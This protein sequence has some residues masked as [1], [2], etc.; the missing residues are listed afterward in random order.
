MAGSS[1]LA[2]AFY[3]LYFALGIPAL[4]WA[5]PRLPLSFMYWVARWA[6]IVP[7]NLVRPKYLRAI[8]GNLSRVLARPAGHPEVRRVAWQMTFEHAYHWIDFFRWSQATTEALVAQISVIEGAEHFEAAR[9]SGHGTLLLSAHMGNP[10]IGAAT[11]G[12]DLEPVHILYWRDRFAKAED[13]RTQMRLKGNVHGIPVDASLFSVVPALRVLEDG[14]IVAAH[15][16]RDFNDQ[17]WPAEFFGAPASFPPGP[18]LL[19]ARANALVIPTFFL[20][21][22]DRTFHVIWRAPLEMGEGGSLQARARRAMDAWVRILEDVVRANPGQWYTFYP[23]W[24][25]PP[26]SA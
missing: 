14:G 15:G 8:K 1:R 7:F 2:Q 18:F 24:T 21:R 12:H 5:A 6:V 16:D 22:P 17:G 26:T 4:V 11:I 3:R 19:A 9:R 10:E 13:F 20:V 25:P 23:Y